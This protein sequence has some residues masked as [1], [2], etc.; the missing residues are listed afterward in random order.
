ML[1]VKIKKM[2]KYKIYCSDILI[3]HKSQGMGALTENWK[4]NHDKLVDKWKNK[5]YK[6]PIISSDFKKKEIVNNIVEIEI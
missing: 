3:F 4:V 1:N 5:G 2:S 6:F